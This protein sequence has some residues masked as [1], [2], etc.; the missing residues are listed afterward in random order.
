MPSVHG[1]GDTK[2]TQAI[3]NLFNNQY[4]QPSANEKFLN[5]NG[6]YTKWNAFWQAFTVLVDKNPKVP[7]ISKLNKLNQAVEREAA[8]VIWMFEFDKESYQLVK[9]ALVNEYGDPALCAN[10]MLRDMQNLDRVKDNILRGF[11]TCIYEANSWY[12]NSSVC[13]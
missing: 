4:N 7:A 13:T 2:F 1:A 10:K 9:M 11:V 12:F 5:F 3:K 6:N 8:A